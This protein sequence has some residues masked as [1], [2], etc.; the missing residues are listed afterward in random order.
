[1]PKTKKRTKKNLKP[2][3]KPSNSSPLIWMAILSFVIFALYILPN[4]M[5]NEVEISYNS[6][7]LLVA[8][9]ELVGRLPAHIPFLGHQYH[10]TRLRVVLRLAS[11]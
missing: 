11:P 3:Q 9:Q 4:D 8:P 2:K 6:Y 5:N 7:Q 10:S 1:M